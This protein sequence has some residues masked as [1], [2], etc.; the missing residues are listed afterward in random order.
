MEAK[1]GFD[2]LWIGLARPH[3]LDSVFQPGIDIL[4]RLE[5]LKIQVTTCR[6]GTGIFRRLLSHGCEIAAALDLLQQASGFA[7]SLL[8][9]LG[10]VVTSIMKVRVGNW[11]HQN[12]SD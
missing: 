7:L 9:R 11:R 4:D 6:S 2:D 1:A 8:R 3:F 5:G 12:V 10:I